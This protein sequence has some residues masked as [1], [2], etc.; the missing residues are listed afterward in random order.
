MSISSR[1]RRPLVAVRTARRGC[2]RRRGRCEGQIGH[3]LV[4]RRQ[5][6]GHRPVLTEGGDDRLQL[7]VTAR[8]LAEPAL[9]ADHRRIRQLDEDGL[10]FVLDVRQPVQHGLQRTGAVGASRASRRCRRWRPGPPQ[11]ALNGFF[12]RRRRQRPRPTL[13]AWARRHRVG[14]SPTAACGTSGFPCTWSRTSTTSPDSRPATRRSSRSRSTSWGRSATCAWPTSSAISGW[15]LS[16]WCA[17][18]RRSRRSAWISPR[19]RSRPP[20]ALADEVG[21]AARA[22]FVQADVH[23]AAATL[24]AAQLRRR[25][26]RERGAVLAA[27]SPASGPKQCALLLRPGGW[28]YLCEFHPVGYCLDQATPTVTH[29][30]FATDAHH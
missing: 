28:L 24:G 22:R 14:W 18:I 4:G 13:P 3:H 26:H 27:G 2:S 23:A 9:V 15:T 21:L 10:V 12:A 16:T 17:C 19:R 8:G 1:S 30:Y 6:R 11:T 5:V 29:D 25:L 7:L 20:S